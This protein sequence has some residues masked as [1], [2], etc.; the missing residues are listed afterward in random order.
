MLDGDTIKVDPGDSVAVNVICRLD[1][2]LLSA[3]LIVR[4]VRSAVALTLES[5]L[6]RLVIAF[7]MLSNVSEGVVV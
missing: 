4:L 2:P 7:T 3:K 5:L 1:S 6:R